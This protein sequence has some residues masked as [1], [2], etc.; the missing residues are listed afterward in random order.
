MARGRS[1]QPNIAL[2]AREP[3]SNV[4]LN[5]NDKFLKCRHNHLNRDFF[6]LHPELAI[7]P[8]GER[9]QANRELAHQ[10][11]RGNHVAE[12]G[13]RAQ[14][15]TD[16]EENGGVVV[17]ARTRSMSANSNE[18]VTIYDTGASHHFVP[19]KSLFVSMSKRSKPF[20]FDQAVGNSSLTMQGVAVCKIGDINFKLENALNLPNS[21]C[22]I[23]SAGRLQRR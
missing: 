11:G 15:E 3:P 19:C 1:A 18:Y 4:A 23:I 16:N 6:R 20:L 12:I 2:A 17:A 22:I 13:G 21:T 14:V 7:G 9:W 5:P 8:K 10:R